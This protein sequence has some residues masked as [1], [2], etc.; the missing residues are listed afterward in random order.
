VTRGAAAVLLPAAALAL[1]GCSKNIDEHDAE[2]KIAASVRKT[3]GA[4]LSVDCP[5]GVPSKKGERFTCTAMVAGRPIDI[6]VEVLSDD[7][8]LR[9]AEVRPRNPGP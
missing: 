2:G 7:G 1:G 5:G 3:S 8:R 6:N 9:L 4:Q